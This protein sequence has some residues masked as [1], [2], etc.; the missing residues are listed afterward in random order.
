[1]KRR[2]DD[3]FCLLVVVI[4]VLGS[5]LLLRTVFDRSLEAYT[6]KVQT[7]A[8]AERI[9][10]PLQDAEESSVVSE[11]GYL[12]QATPDPAYSEMW[13]EG[14]DPYGASSLPD[15]PMQN[16]MQWAGYNSSLLADILAIDACNNRYGVQ[17]LS[18]KRAFMESFYSKTGYAW[19][20]VMQINGDIPVIF[21][22]DGVSDVWTQRTDDAAAYYFFDEQTD[23]SKTELR[24]T[25]SNALLEWIETG[26]ADW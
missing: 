10:T 14:Y 18:V 11:G 9:R 2:G 21:Y 19:Y 8:Q 23:D 22:Y 26:Y 25:V 3:F 7:G 17:P 15:S 12:P 13:G 24:I 4:C 20:G 5:G 6:N 1:M 16:E